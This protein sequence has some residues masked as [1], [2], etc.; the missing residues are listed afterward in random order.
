MQFVYRLALLLG[1]TVGEIGKMPI[2]ELRGWMQFLA[3]EMPPETAIELAIARLHH[4][5]LRANSA[6]GASIPR[7]SQLMQ[8]RDPWKEQVEEE[9]GETVFSSFLANM[10]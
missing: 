6:R 3:V 9:N 1:K 5:F 10:G 7:V 4:S 2:S 8:P